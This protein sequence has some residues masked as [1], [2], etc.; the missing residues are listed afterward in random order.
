MVGFT[1]LVLVVWYSDGTAGVVLMGLLGLAAFFFCASTVT[2][3][4]CTS[5]AVWSYV[6][7]VVS[8]DLLA[9]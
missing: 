6:A 3:L 8:S 5:V 9:C 4:V 1:T 7:E 2:T